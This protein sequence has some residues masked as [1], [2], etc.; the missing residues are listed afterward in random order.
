MAENTFKSPGFFEQEIEL[1]AEKQEP[2]GV[3]AGIIGAAQM[4][5]AFVPLTLGTFTDFENR[6]GTLTPEKFAPYAVREWLKNRQSVTFMRVLGAGA[7]ATSTDFTNTRSYGVAK[8]AGFKAIDTGS[9]VGGKYL[10]ATQFL[11]ANHVISANSDIG[12][13]IFTDNQTWKSTTS[14]GTG[15]PTDDNINILSLIHI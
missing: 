2:T 1:T 9:T 8:N 15:T 4:G 10:G 12:F 5:P 3:P 7:N 13:P 11:T 14:E 6:F